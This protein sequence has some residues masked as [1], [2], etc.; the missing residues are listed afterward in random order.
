MADKGAGRDTVDTIRLGTGL[1]LLALLVAFV[2]DNTHDVT[3]GF[4]FAEKDTRLIYVLVVTALIGAA[5]DRLWQY[6]RRD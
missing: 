3:V 4:V 5:L 6:S 1:V 2:V